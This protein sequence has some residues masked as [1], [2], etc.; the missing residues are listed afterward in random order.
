MEQ[1]PGPV[2]WAA[3]NPAPLPGAVRLWTWQALAHGAEVVSYFRWRQVPYAQEQM[4]AGLNRPDNVLDV[5]GEEARTVARELTDVRLGTMQPAPVA[6][7]LDYESE[8]LFRI[9]PQGREFSYKMQAWRWYSAARELGLDVDILPPG[10][11]LSPYRLVLVPSLAVVRPAMLERLRTAQAAI[12][13]GARTGS[14]TEH[15]AIP[16]NLPPGQLQDLLPIKIVRVESL[17][18]DMPVKVEGEVAGAAV[19]WREFVE[20][21]LP[22]RAD[23][24]DG[25]GAF[26]SHGRQHYLACCPDKR[27]LRSVLQRMASAAGLQPVDLP[28]GVRLRRRGDLT[29]AF[30]FGAATVTVPAPVGAEFILG[31]R[32]MAAADVAA[33]RS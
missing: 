24:E 33:W 18:P 4:H 8:W 5:G 25:G 17:R 11:D 15:F 10:G 9:Q 31:D 32:R 27:L 7:V 12:L 2:N 16:P 21:D 30:N 23:F 19:L 1:Q 29:F 6:L 13:Y 14:K 22:P 3:H 28:V 26:F 20:T